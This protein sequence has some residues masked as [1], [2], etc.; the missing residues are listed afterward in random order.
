MTTH[1]LCPALL[2]ALVAASGC[3]K[4][5]PIP[6]GADGAAAWLYRH[7][8]GDATD[9]IRAAIDQIVDELGVTTAEAGFVEGL[10]E[11]LDAETVG[12]VGR[13]AVEALPPEEQEAITEEELDAGTVVQLSD[14]QGM[15]VASVIPCPVQD[16]LDVYV[17]T[18]QDVVH[19]GYE[20]YDRAYTAD[21]DAFD[22]GEPL[23]W[24][25]NYTVSVLTSTYDATILGQVRWVDEDRTYAVARAHLPEPAEFTRGGKYFRQD[26]QLDLYAPTDSGETVHVFAVWRDM[27]LAGFHSSNTGYIATVSNEF[28]AADGRTAEACGGG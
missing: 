23:S 10:L 2:L 21:R 12:V 26:Y 18:D 7:Q 19:G 17:R 15:V 5:E 6:E 27:N 3:R 13:S 4:L 9:E 20:A 28:R 22:D 8:D 25:T 11:S 16:V 24:E 1:H 14:Q